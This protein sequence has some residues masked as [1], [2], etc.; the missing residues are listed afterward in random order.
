MPAKS[1]QQKGNRSDH[2]HAWP[3]LGEHAERRVE[4]MEDLVWSLDLE[5]RWTS[6]NR[7]ATLHL[8][9]Y[10]PNEMLGRHFCEFASTEQAE[11]DAL[12]FKKM[13]KG[14]SINSFDTI[15][16]KKDGSS[17]K[18]HF[19]SILIKIENN[20]I[21]GFN[22]LAKQISSKEIY[23]KNIL[24]AIQDGIAVHSADLEILKI[25]KALE[26]LF[27]NGMPLLG[28]KCHEAYFGKDKPCDPCPALRAI[29]NNGLEIEHIP[30]LKPSSENSG[31]LEICAFPLPRNNGGPLGVVEYVKDVTEKIEAEQA[32]KKSEESYKALT[33]NLP[34][35][36]YR[37]FLDRDTELQVFN[38]HL[39]VLTGYELREIRP[40]TDSHFCP[41]DRIV[42]PE[43]R[44]R[45]RLSIKEAIARQGAFEVEY[46][47]RHKSGQILNVRERGK[48]VQG[49]GG[50]TLHYDGF[51]FDVTRRRSL[52]E[53]LLKAK[54][55]ESISV[56]AGGIAH[57]FNNL[58]AVILGNLS[59]IKTESGISESV[60][61]RLN[62]AEQAVLRARDLTQQITTFSRGGAPV[63]RTARIETV[64]RDAAG[65]A[66]A[67][68]NALLD[69]RIPGD[70]W[71]AVI[72]E[73]QIK[74]VFA[75]LLVN[76]DQAMPFGGRIIVTARNLEL[77]PHMEDLSPF[78]SQ[79]LYVK[80]TVQ[81]E[82]VGIPEAYLD[83]IF[84][85]YFSTR[86]KGTRKGLGLGLA[87]CHSI[88]KR[89]GGH[90]SVTS[91]QN[92]GTTFEIYLP[93]SEV[94]E[95][96]FESPENP[97]GGIS[98]ARVLLMDDEDLLRILAEEIVTKLGYEIKTVKTG[99]EALSVYASAMEE[100]NPF[101][102]VVLD[103]TIRGGMGGQETMEELLRIDPEVKGII[104][105]GYFSDPVMAQYRKHG[106]RGVIPKPYHVEQL[107]R[108]IQGVLAGET[109]P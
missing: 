84:D 108:V 76:A 106:F 6:L 81:D 101:D 54:T 50:K 73:N 56:M 64:I 71:L 10:E 7:K 15:H 104:S 91:E 90:I 105:S 26:K 2:P 33:A 65:V 22:G 44:E 48:P 25:N 28:R 94:P 102:V 88:I 43:D 3:S 13:L 96:E 49:P 17:I 86:E 29:E 78:L 11:K 98:P 103:L 82:G 83:K 95:K 70:T 99:E 27:S 77:R 1:S 89:H 12:A 75:N 40:D 31:W 80:I 109:A 72:D 18:L 24:D 21:T 69:I 66:I 58:L 46:R 92:K 47:I 63:T 34:G 14:E 68:S 97:K 36:A 79:G 37:S 74:Q 87:T 55:L 23:Y 100:G 53:E 67:G 32:L 62:D 19:E 61:K 42:I 93:A 16:I 107:S 59:I 85:P 41:L 4:S 52:E 45:L 51:I 30:Y 5:G 60:L 9:G 20:K 8:Y 35:L 57:D 38:N 39:S